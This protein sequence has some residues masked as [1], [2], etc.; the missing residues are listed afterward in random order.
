MPCYKGINWQKQASE[1]SSKFFDSKAE[2]TENAVELLIR[3]DGYLT[4]WMQ[5]AKVE[6]TYEGLR[7]LLQK[8]QLLKT[9]DKTLACLSEKEN[10]LQRNRQQRCMVG[11][12][13]VLGMSWKEMLRS[14]RMYCSGRN[15][16]YVE[17]K[18]TR[19]RTARWSHCSKIKAGQ[20]RT[21]PTCQIC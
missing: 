18:G 12:S 14:F 7:D 21:L 15:A 6:E 5:L 1:Q 8:E 2:I 16:T 3:I 10:Q 20:G 9:C 4:R 17:Q 13:Q 19:Q 11:L